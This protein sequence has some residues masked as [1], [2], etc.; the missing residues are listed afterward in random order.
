MQLSLARKGEPAQFGRVHKPW[1]T[2]FA[3][4]GTI[5]AATAGGAGKRHDIHEFLTMG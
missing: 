2:I 1:L 3:Y 4:P 5:Q